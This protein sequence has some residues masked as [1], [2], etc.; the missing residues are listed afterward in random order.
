MGTYCTY[1][2]VDAVTWMGEFPDPVAGSAVP[3]CGSLRIRVLCHAQSTETDCASQTASVIRDR[4]IV[5]VCSAH[6]QV[7]VRKMVMKCT[8]NHQS[9]RASYK[10]G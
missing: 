5:T 2:N 8:H 10:N 4:R 7:G 6:A 3:N 1:Q 9:L